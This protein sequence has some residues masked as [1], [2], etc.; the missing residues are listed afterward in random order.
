MGRVDARAED[1]R[2][3]RQVHVCLARSSASRAAPFARAGSGTAP[4]IAIACCGLVPHVTCGASAEQ[5]SS[6]RASQRAPSSEARPSHARRPGRA[7][8]PPARTAARDPGDRRVVGRPRCP[9]T[10]ELDGH[11]AQR[12]AALDG[13]RAH[14]RLGRTRWRRPSPTGGA[15]AP[16]VA[17]G[18]CPWA[19]RRARGVIE[20][21]AHSPGRARTERLRGHRVLA[22]GGA[23]AQASAPIPPTVP[24]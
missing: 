24:V 15:E 23:D 22:F 10:P 11:V 3:R 1:R 19:R 6:R 16:D 21:D 17:R 12:E 20:L 14:R 5:S 8:R 13:K 2:T 4:S 18:P 9:S 7:S